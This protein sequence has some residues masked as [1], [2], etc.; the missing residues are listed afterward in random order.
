MRIILTIFTYVLFLMAGNSY[1]NDS[2]SDISYIFIV[3]LAIFVVLSII[4]WQVDLFLV[5]IKILELDYNEIL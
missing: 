5:Y 4:L 1:E 3:L 2:N